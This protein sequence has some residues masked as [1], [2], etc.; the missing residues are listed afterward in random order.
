MPA[1]SALTPE[2]E[3]Y[4]CPL[5]GA[6][7]LIEPSIVGDVC[8]PRC[9]QLI[10]QIRNRLRQILAEQLGVPKEQI[11]EST[12]FATD[13]RADSLDQVEVVVELEEEYDVSIGRQDAQRIQTPED[14]I[15]QL[16]RILIERQRGF[17][18]SDPN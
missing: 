8:C 16:L 17:P 5:C 18:P 15:R 10:W 11:A 14:A 6:T 2:G 4:K 1:P 9:G 13:L 12:A 3:L 7:L